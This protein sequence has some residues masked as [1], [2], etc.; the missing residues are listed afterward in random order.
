MNQSVVPGDDKG[1][2]V[3]VKGGCLEGIT[4]DVWT[5]AAHLWTKSALVSIPEGVDRWEE[6]PPPRA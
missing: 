3:A 6:E 2:F 4:G 5:E 1:G